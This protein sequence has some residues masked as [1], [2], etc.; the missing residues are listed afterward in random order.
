MNR[1]CFAILF[2]LAFSCSVKE[3]RT[4]CPCFLSLKVLPQAEHVF[5]G[6]AAWCGLFDG[7]GSVLTENSLGRMNVRDTLLAFEVAPRRRISAVVSN[8]RPQNGAVKASEGEEFCAL[9]A[10]RKELDCLGEEARDSICIQN[11]EFCTLTVQLSAQ[12]VPLAEDLVLNVSAPFCG[13]EFPSLRAARGNYTCRTPFNSAGVAVV[14]IPRQ[15]DVG[16][17]ISV[18]KLGRFSSEID[19]YTIMDTSDYDW[20]KESLSDFSVT[21]NLNSISGHCAVLDWEVVD[22]GNREF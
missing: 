16:L 6:G 10:F 13:T 20:M 19:L 18:E 7:D 4:E 21:V 14:R 9:Y 11:K 17:L 8:H 22:S 3:D 2:L 1:L 5:P 15:A 12:A